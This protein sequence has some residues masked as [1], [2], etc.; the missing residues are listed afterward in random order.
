MMVELRPIDDY[1]RAACEHL[2][3]KDDQKQYIASN[4][5]S[6]ITA[7]E[8]AEIA[9]PF[10]IFVDDRVVGFTMF[11]FDENNE[12]PE[13][14]YWLWRFMIDEKEQGKGIWKIRFS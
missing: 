5:D 4:A 10:A 2:S 14:K 11:A 13:D 9:R 7:K 6:L 8:N 12:D 3:V 1:S